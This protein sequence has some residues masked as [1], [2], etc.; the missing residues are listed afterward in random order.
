MR[1]YLKRTAGWLTAGWFWSVVLLVLP[2]CGLNA[3]GTGTAP[4]QNLVQGE[5][6]WSS[7]IM[8]DIEKIGGRH[9][10]ASQAEID[11]GIKFSD[12]ALALAEGRIAPYG[13]D[14][15]DTGKKNCNG[16]PE[17]VEFEGPFPH[18][19]AVCLNCSQITSMAD[20][21]TAC[22]QRCYDFHGTTEEGMLFPDIPP[23]PA[24][25]TFCDSHTRVSTNG[26]TTGAPMCYANLCTA[27]GNT[28]G[29]ADPRAQPE[30]VIWTIK[31]NTEA[32]GV[33]GNDLTRNA[34]AGA[35][36]D[37][38]AV[39]EQW[40]THGNAWVEFSVKDKTQSHFLGFT[41]VKDCPSPCA[42]D[43]PGYISIGFALL[44]DADGRYYI[45]ESGIGQQGP[46][47]NTSWG[48][49]EPTDR[50]RITLIQD[51][52]DSTKARVIYS[53]VGDPQPIYEHL[54]APISYPIRVDTSLKQVG[55]ALTN[56]R[57]VRIQFEQ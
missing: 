8:C 41:S 5:Q 12:A 54:D 57:L 10:P 55:A 43:D 56:V 49:Y 1:D 52:N 35:T 3:Q 40:I 26:V 25:Q 34:G 32:G 27:D 36:Y 24:T 17:I 6:P 50:F 42:A 28:T 51:E 39:S 44:L 29:A 2:A 46:D 21:I 30:A 20:A 37:A 15:T 9:C 31:N 38:G 13:V 19:V 18:G 14:D 22:R 11:G 53:R 23:T 48:T 4:T 7:M 45:T 47:L 16:D 33:D